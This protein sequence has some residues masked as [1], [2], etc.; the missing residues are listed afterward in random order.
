[1]HRLLLSVHDRG[2]PKEKDKHAVDANQ[3]AKTSS[4]DLDVSHSSVARPPMREHNSEKSIG[5]IPF[6]QSPMGTPGENLDKNTPQSTWG[7]PQSVS[8]S[9]E[10][11]PLQSAPE[12]LVIA[13]SAAATGA[14]LAQPRIQRQPSL[15]SA[16]RL[17]RGGEDI[18]TARPGSEFSYRTAADG[19]ESRQN[20][21]KR[22]TRALPSEDVRKA[23]EAT[24]LAEEEAERERKAREEQAEKL[25]DARVEQEETGGWTLVKRLVLKRNTEE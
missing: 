23:L 25:D 7:R 22:K 2:T 19:G 17:G 9:M 11:K 24:V 14:T 15:L 4:S 21:D 12:R 18:D 16:L 3:D 1:M 5:P 10:M 13:P 6:T 20:S 8:D